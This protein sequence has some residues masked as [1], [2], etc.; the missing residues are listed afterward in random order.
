MTPPDAVPGP[1]PRNRHPKGA[2]TGGQFA[3]ATHA[4][5]TA[6]LAVTDG[7]RLDDLDLPSWPPAGTDCPEQSFS[8]C[9]EV[10]AAYTQYLREHGVVAEWVQVCGAR[11][12]FPDAQPQWQTLDPEHWQHCLTR[13]TRPD[14]LALYID[15][16]ARQFDPDA[17]HPRVSA[18]DQNEW[19]TTYEVTHALDRF[20]AAWE[21]EKRA[22][23]RTSERR[24]GRPR[25]HQA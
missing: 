5:S 23:D 25:T 15:W 19:H 20:L 2:P 12:E 16:T 4:E 7:T 9:K 21:F 14:G 3:G 11:G 18:V 8:R 17:D 1:A 10:S 24:A 6:S 13:I 22:R